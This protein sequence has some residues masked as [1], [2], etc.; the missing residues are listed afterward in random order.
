[1]QRVWIPD[2]TL[3]DDD[4][5][6]IDDERILGDVTSLR[7]SSWQASNDSAFE[8]TSVHEDVRIDTHILMMMIIIF[9]FLK[10]IS[11][12]VVLD[13]NVLISYLPLVRQLHATITR[14]K[15]KN[16]TLC[17]PDIVVKELNFLK[18]RNPNPNTRALAQAANVWLLAQVRNRSGPLRGQQRHERMKTEEH[19]RVRNNPIMWSRITNGHSASE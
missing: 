16:V 7:A 3:N 17:L 13:S 1:M 4:A 12:F 18:E 8:D 19:S 11:Y 14:Q 5:M 10:G 9:N 6:D 15:L 2:H